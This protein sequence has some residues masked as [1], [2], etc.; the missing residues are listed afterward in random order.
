MSMDGV[1]DG[2]EAAGGDHRDDGLLDQNRGVRAHDVA[3]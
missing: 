2:V 1:H 3:A